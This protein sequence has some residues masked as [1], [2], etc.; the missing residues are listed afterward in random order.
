MYQNSAENL[1]LIS[2][3]DS[4]KLIINLFEGSLELLKENSS[5]F[6][7]VKRDVVTPGGTTHAGLQYLETC[8]GTFDKSLVGAYIRAKELG[9]QLNESLSD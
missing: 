7:E 9:D 5:S 2:D 8:Q 1:N 6:S 4:R 3:V